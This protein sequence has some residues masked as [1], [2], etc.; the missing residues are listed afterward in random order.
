M[1][2]TTLLKKNFNPLNC[3]EQMITSCSFDRLGIDIVFILFI[4]SFDSIN[5]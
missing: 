5:G 1:I 3:P 2:F 4:Y